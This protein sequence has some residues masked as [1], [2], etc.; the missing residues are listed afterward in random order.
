[1]KAGVGE[2]RRRRKGLHRPGG[3]NGTLAPIKDPG[4]GVSRLRDARE[5]DDQSANRGASGV[6]FGA[7]DDWTLLDSRDLLWWSASEL[8]RL[9]SDEQFPRA[10]LGAPL[11]HRH[12]VRPLI[13]PPPSRSDCPRPPPDQPQSASLSG[14]HCAT[15]LGSLALQAQ[16]WKMTRGHDRARNN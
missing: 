7:R 6:E 15:A 13:S 10:Q 4:H 16:H 12:A 14:R 5:G 2:R 1:M 3:R 9:I 8:L 11:R